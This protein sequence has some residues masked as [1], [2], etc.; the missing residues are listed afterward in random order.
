MVLTILGSGGAV[1][2]HGRHPSAQLLR[3]AE[4][5]CL[6]DCGEGTQFRLHDFKLPWSKIRYVFISHLH[7]DHVYGLPPLITS[8]HL[9]GRKM[10]LDVFGPPELE[11]LVSGIFSLTHCAPSFPIRW[12]GIPNGS[13]GMLLEEERFTVRALPLVHRIQSSGFLFTELPRSGRS[14]V[15]PGASFAYCSDTAPSD[16]L[17]AL[18]QG[19]DLLYHEATFLEEHAD[20]AAMTVHSTAL[21][22][23]RIALE[24]KAGR[25]LLGHVSARYPDPGL[26]LAEARRIFDQTEMTREGSTFSVPADDLNL[27][28]R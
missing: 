6:I 2:A 26:V 19:V 8:W 9:T 23:A 14:G 18:L 11:D 24:A 28:P 16:R 25:L 7:G 12:H 5:L 3:I 17:P 4:T 10:P 1:P 27:I 22:A 21:Q 13:E 15:F 20:K